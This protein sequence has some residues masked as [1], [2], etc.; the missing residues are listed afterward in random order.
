MAI[1]FHC[2]P[3]LGSRCAERKTSCQR[4]GVETIYAIQE[5]R[6]ASEASKQRRPGRGQAASA[7]DRTA[8]CQAPS[9]PPTGGDKSGCQNP[10]V[11]LMDAT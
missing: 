5:H 9:R 3:L 4:N 11:V 6:N 8:A 1:A 2:H 7:W 10:L